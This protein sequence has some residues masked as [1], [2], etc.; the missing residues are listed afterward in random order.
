MKNSNLKAPYKN[1]RYRVI[2]S[3]SKQYLID[4]DSPWFGYVF[5]GLSWLVPQK[6]YILDERD[7]DDLLVRH[8]DIKN[9]NK[10]SLIWLSLIILG[11]NIILPN[12]VNTFYRNSTIKY[13]QIHQFGDSVTIIPS[14]MHS[15]LLLILASFPAI[16][17]R[18]FLAQRSKRGIVNKI[19]YKN[20]PFTKIK[21]IPATISIVIKNIVVYFFLALLVITA[22]FFLVISEGYWII[23]LSFTLLLLFFLLTNNLAFSNDKYKIREIKEK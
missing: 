22:G 6:A 5:F 1:N 12:L 14:T 11:F 8:V 19:Q 2:C 10:M 20:L 15:L 13:S 3:D 23:S 16:I 4:A 21:I 9:N 7:A 18:I 17:I